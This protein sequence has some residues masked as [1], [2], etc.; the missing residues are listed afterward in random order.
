[1][2]QAFGLFIYHLELINIGRGWEKNRFR[3]KILV[4]LN[5]RKR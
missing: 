3:R 2:K 1:M 5:S 4:R